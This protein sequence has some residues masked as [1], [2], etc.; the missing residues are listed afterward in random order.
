M[1]EKDAEGLLRQL[2]IDLVEI[3]VDA[4]DK[5]E[6]PMHRYA[7]ASRIRTAL[8][9]VGEPYYTADEVDLDTLDLEGRELHSALEWREKQR[10]K[11]AAEMTTKCDQCEVLRRNLETQTH[12]AN[13]AELERDAANERVEKAET[14]IRCARDHLDCLCGDLGDREPAHAYGARMILAGYISERERDE[15]NKPYAA[16][17]TVTGPLWTQRL[18]PDEVRVLSAPAGDQHPARADIP[19]E[20]I[21]RQTVCGF[22]DAERSGGEQ[23]CILTYEWFADLTAF[24]LATIR[25]Y[26]ELDAPPPIKLEVR[27]VDVDATPEQDGG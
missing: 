11:E 27:S 2:V 10:A 6:M 22:D 5:P 1:S 20:L 9:N 7:C 24:K 13:A 8:C 17:G 12:R 18:T 3:V 21:P 26:C 14:T 4:E 15:A 23:G 16:H 19:P 25:L